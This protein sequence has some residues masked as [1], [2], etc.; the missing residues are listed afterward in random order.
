MTIGVFNKG[1]FVD[2]WLNEPT[3][4]SWV[5]RTI[6]AKGWLRQ[7]IEVYLYEISRNGSE[8]FSFDSEKNLKKL[9]IE[10]I[11]IDDASVQA[12]TVEQTFNKIPFFLNGSFVE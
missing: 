3:E 7:D 2:F 5:E 12:V 1:V 10:E 8:I 11:V 6:A 4:K 9:K